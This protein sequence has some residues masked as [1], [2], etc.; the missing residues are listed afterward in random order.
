VVK[1]APPSL[2]HPLDELTLG[3]EEILDVYGD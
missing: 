3:Q 2:E 1:L